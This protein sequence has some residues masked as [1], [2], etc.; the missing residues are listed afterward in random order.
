L[1]GVTGPVVFAMVILVSAA[2]RPGYSHVTNLI[3]ELGA[4]GTPYAVLMNYAG[5][6]PA[7]LMLAAFGVA[8]AGVLPR[9]RLALAGAVLVTLFG[10]GVASSGVIS[11]DPG[12]PQSGGSFE[13]LVHDRIAPIAFLS[14]I[15]GAAILGFHFRR[16]PAWRHLA[17]YSLLTSGIA[18][19]CLVALAN[20]LESRVLTGLWQR[21]MLTSLLLWC[22]VIGLGAYRGPA[23]PRSPSNSGM[24]PT[25]EKPRAADP[26]R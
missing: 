22:A 5:F 13:N 12:C 19:L 26:G 20:S 24:Q 15:V 18:L 11:C 25:R 21:L 23:S 17:A 8:L 3:S 9:Q 10:A 2:L 7:G 16:L 14:L 6:V 4:T 1:G